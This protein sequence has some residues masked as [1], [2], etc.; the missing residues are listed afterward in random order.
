M[1]VATAGTIVNRKYA[2]LERRISAGDFG[3]LVVQREGY[4]GFR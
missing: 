1:N 4:D 3:T 2:H